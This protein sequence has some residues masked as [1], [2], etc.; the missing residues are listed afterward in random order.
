ME[1]AAP[2]WVA[3]PKWAAAP[4]THG[5]TPLG[6][7]RFD[8]S[9]LDDDLSSSESEGD[10]D[11]LLSSREDVLSQCPTLEARSQALISRLR[12]A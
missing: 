3:A 5:S 2:G 12:K 6:I 9:L 4:C 1:R 11:D 7:R 8:V 10:I